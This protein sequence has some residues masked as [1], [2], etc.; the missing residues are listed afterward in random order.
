MRHLWPPVVCVCG[1]KD[2]GKTTLIEA[3]IPRLKERDLEV[4]VLK[5]D[6]HGL[7]IDKPGKDTDRYFQAGADVVAHDD[8]QLFARRRLDGR[9][10]LARLAWHL[11]GRYD[12]VLVEGHK[13]SPL[14][15]LWVAGEGEDHAPTDVEHLIGAVAR[16]EGM[17]DEALDL[18]LKAVADFYRHVT[19]VAGILIGG[20]S[21][22]MGRPKALLPYKHHTLIEHAVDVVRPWVDDVVL[23]GAGPC[24][25]G[26]T[27]VARIADA[28]LVQG[29]MA[30]ILGALRWA[31]RVR[32]LILPCDLPLITNEAVEW[33]LEQPV[34]GRP[35][36]MPHIAGQAMPDPLFAVYDPPA[37]RWLEDAA[38]TEQFSLRHAFPEAAVTDC[39]VPPE[40]ADAWHNVNTPDDWHRLSDRL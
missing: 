8:T 17:V 20:D 9:I 40:H 10:S 36:T 33:L 5:H 38:E 1:W 24:P 14:P 30:G 26:L 32:W 22:R 37:R 15:K 39:P 2:A 19:T 23:L 35:V 27:G 4:G 21:S 18:I 34:Y 13:A 28:P 11:G 6:A 7:E 25:E 16:G 3:L 31:P 12:L 29:P